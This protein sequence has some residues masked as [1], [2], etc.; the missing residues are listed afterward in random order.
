LFRDPLEGDRENPAFNIQTADVMATIHN[1][2][3]VQ[4][5]MDGTKKRKPED[6]DLI[7]N[8]LLARLKKRRSD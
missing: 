3:K 8:E 2:E 7:D 5:Q 4:R 6:V 1:F